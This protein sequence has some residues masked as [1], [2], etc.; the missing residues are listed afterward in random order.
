[1]ANKRSLNGLLLET[2][3]I[4]NIARCVDILFTR[5]GRKLDKMISAI[6]VAKIDKKLEGIREA[7]LR[8][9]EV[10]E[11]AVENGGF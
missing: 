6:E 3:L 2:T 5:N 9:A 10:L 4:S 11:K 7:L 1:M 8:I